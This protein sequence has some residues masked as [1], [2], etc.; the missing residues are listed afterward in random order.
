MRRTLADTGFTEITRHC[1]REG[2]DPA[3][4]IDDPKYEWE[5]L[6]VEAR[7]LQP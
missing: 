2:A 6:Y 3:L 1:Y 5:S 7:Q 4:A